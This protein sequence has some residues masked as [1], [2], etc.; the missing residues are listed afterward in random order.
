MYDTAPTLLA[1]VS[2][3]EHVSANVSIP[4]G[5][6]DTAPTL[7]AGVS[8]RISTGLAASAAELYTK[9]LD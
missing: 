3:C 9:T 4:S 2:I 1:G 5:E 7:L 8:F 6:K